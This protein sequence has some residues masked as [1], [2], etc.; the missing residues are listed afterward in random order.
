MAAIGLGAM[1]ALAAGC[2]DDDSGSG[3]TKDSGTDTNPPGDSGGTDAGTDTGTDSSKPPPPFSANIGFFNSRSQATDSGIP[4]LLIPSYYVQVLPAQPARQ[5]D[6]YQPGGF[7]PLAC[8][9]WKFTTTDPNAPTGPN[10]SDGDMGNITLEGHTGG[11]TAAG[12][13]PKPITC[14]RKEYVPGKFKY[15]CDLPAAPADTFLKPADSLVIKAAGGKDSQEASVPTG[16]SPIT[17][18]RVT[19]NLWGIPPSALDGNSDF[20]IKYDCGATACPNATLVVV[21]IETTDGVAPA[22]AGPPTPFDFYPPQK[23]FGQVL[24]LDLWPKNTTGYKVPKGAIAQLPQ[25]WKAARVTV[26]PVSG[27]QGLSKN[28][29]PV[30]TFAGDGVFGI[31]QHP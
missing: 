17:N 3:G 6:F 13:I 25:S 1:G 27:A 9:A 16:V 5:P 23:E 14:Q 22:D 4:E 19:T 26:V 7:P 20:E 15:V 18:L 30:S 29:I 24:C 11:T 31:T 28:G 2:G 8:F 10:F 12:P 21:Q